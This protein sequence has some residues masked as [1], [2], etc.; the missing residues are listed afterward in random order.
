MSP[1]LTH[2]SLLLEEPDSPE[3]VTTSFQV[4]LYL[5]TLISQV[6]KSMYMQISVC[7]SDNQQHVC[8][9]CYNLYMQVCVHMHKYKPVFVGMGILL[10]SDRTTVSLLCLLVTVL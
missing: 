5:A 10:C 8:L 3:T 6:V 9:S 1:S 7:D 4:T 2:K